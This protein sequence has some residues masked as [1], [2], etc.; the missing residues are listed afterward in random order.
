MLVVGLII[1]LE[2]AIFFFSFFCSFNFDSYNNSISS[3]FNQ[4]SC[5]IIFRGGEV[6]I[7]KAATVFFS[8]NLG[9]DHLQLLII[10]GTNVI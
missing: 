9:H 2:L 4:N 8:V 6:S 5:N 1:V 3:N 7:I 10:K